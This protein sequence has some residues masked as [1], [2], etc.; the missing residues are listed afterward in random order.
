MPLSLREKSIKISDKDKDHEVEILI[1]GEDL[2][3]FQYAFINQGQA[4]EL[5]NHLKEQFGL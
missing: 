4:I 1:E 2:S 3:Y 5:I